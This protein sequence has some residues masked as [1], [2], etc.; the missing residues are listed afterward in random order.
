MKKLI[1]LFFII[2]L[3]GGISA[4]KTLTV[5]GS[6]SNPAENSV[7]LLIFNPLLP[8][9]PPA[10]LSDTLDSNGYFS[11]E[12][13]VSSPSFGI[14]QHGDQIADIYL[15][16]GKSLM[17][18]LN[19]EDL[20]NSL[21]FEG[22]LAAENQFLNDYF[23]R[24][25]KDRD[26]LKQ[27]KELQPEEFKDYAATRKAEK[28]KF[29]NGFSATLSQEFYKLAEQK[30]AY[31]WGSDLFT[32]PW[33]HAHFNNTSEPELPA[34][35]L[36]YEKEL[37]LYQPKAKPLP[38]YQEYMYQET[39]ILYERS[40]KKEEKDVNSLPFYTGIYDFAGKHLKGEILEDFRF[41][42]LLE[43]MNENG[44]SGDMTNFTNFIASAT[45]QKYIDTLQTIYNRLLPLTAG[46]PAPAFELSSI[47]GG[48]ISLEQLK[49]KVVYIDF[50]ASWCGPCI[51][52][53]PNAKKMKE[54]FQNQ[55]DLAFVYI[56]VD[57]KEESWRKMVEQQQPEGIHL[58]AKGWEN[59]V[60][61]AYAVHEIPRYV[62]LDRQGRIINANMSAPGDP[63]TIEAIEKALA[64]D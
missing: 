16:P 61:R 2:L 24:F 44:I 7:L 28:E 10:E 26:R 62:L 17:M 11:F 43:E 59:E 49:G 5:K 21:K 50:W 54:H 23:L 4:Q 58:F 3:S 33:A 57:E 40:L 63:A 25:E 22:T 19:A 46:K 64:K 18:D 41:K 1:F 45:R 9:F 42:L 20:H 39:R 35:F 60:S 6:I 12:I 55:P 38:V 32:Y 52:E 48:E 27:M 53:F 47:E 30:I 51:R 8:A 56:S 36:D 31:E 15:E 34:G 14:F 13:K 29:L 37:P